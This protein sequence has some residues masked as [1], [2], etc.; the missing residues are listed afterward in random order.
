MCCHKKPRWKPSG[1]GVRKP[2]AIMIPVAFRYSPQAPRPNFGVN[3]NDGTKYR[4]I[5]GLRHDVPIAW[6]LTT[7]PNQIPI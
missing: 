7:A 6:G 2:Q 4:K 3:Q 1:Q 5:R